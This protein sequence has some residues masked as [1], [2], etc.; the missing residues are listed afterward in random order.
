MRTELIEAIEHNNI[1]PVSKLKPYLWKDEI[2]DL[3]LLTKHMEVYLYSGY[4]PE[5]IDKA[6]LGCYCWSKKIASQLDNRGLIYDLWGTDDNLL[7]FKTDIANL[8]VI[9]SLGAFKRRP[10]IKGGWVRGRAR[11]LGH[12]VRPYEYC[13]VRIQ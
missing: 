2:N 5:T 12:E 11:K 9:L 7:T 8:P 1:M 4:Y 10:S 6:V 13:G 3:F